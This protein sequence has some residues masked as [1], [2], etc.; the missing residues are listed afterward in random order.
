MISK[1]KVNYDSYNDII[2]VNYNINAYKDR[3]HYRLWFY[4]N[5]SYKPNFFLTNI[6]RIRISHNLTFFTI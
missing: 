1:V 3:R 6:Y 4:G 5:T 2:T